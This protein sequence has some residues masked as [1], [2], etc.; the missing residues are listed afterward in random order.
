MLVEHPISNGATDEQWRSLLRSI[1]VRMKNDNRPWGPLA[2]RDFLNTLEHE[3][4]D[5][6]SKLQ[7]FDSKEEAQIELNRKKIS[8]LEEGTK[9]DFAS[10]NEEPDQPEGA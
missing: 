8:I 10:S 2:R 1:G 9:K 5:K 4:P 6:Y 7:F 3:R